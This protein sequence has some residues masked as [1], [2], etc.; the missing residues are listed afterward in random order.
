MSEKT[1]K[2]EISSLSNLENTLSQVLQ[3]VKPDNEFINALKSKLTRIPNIMVETTK[4]GSKFLFV[5]IGVL[6]GIVLVWL[7]GKPKRKQ[8]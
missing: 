2:T 6:I 5:S 8:G 1:Q 7:L 4:K 3:P